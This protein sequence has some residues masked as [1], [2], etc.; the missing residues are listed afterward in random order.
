MLTHYDVHLLL[1]RACY[2]FI[3]KQKVPVEDVLSR[4]LWWIFHDLPFPYLVI[5]AIPVFVGF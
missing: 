4:W 3:Q 5:T 2:Q 1:Q